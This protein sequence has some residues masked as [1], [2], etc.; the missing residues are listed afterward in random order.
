MSV[1]ASRLPSALLLHALV[2]GLVVVLLVMQQPDYPGPKLPEFW[3]VQALVFGALAAVLYL[4]VGWAAPRLLYG[5]GGRWPSGWRSG[6]F[7]ARRAQR[8]FSVRA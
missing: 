5:G 4:D 2:G 7:A 8:G 1:P 6:H 3:L